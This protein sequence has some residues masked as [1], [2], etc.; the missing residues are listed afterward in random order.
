MELDE[1]KKE[2][3]RLG[4]KYSLP[5]FGEVNEAFEIEKIDRDSD[6]L[7]RVVRKVMMEKVVSSLGFVEM[8][9]NPMNAP[10]MYIAYINSMSVD[11]KKSIE[12]IYSDLARV[13]VDALNCEID[14]SEKAE[15]EVVKDIFMVEN[16]YRVGF[17]VKY[18]CKGIKMH[19][20][21][22]ENGT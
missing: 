13:S 7:M 18:F 1:L 16:L 3:G 15:A 22:L 6:S 21:F 17:E 9:L 5:E 4:K 12:K 2:Y 14:Y 8:L 10:R 20:F 11:D 19:F